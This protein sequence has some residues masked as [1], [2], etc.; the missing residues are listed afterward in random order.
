MVGFGKALQSD[1]SGTRFFFVVK[2]PAS[3]YLE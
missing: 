2:K 1:K 3:A